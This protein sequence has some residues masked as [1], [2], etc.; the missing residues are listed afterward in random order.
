MRERL[1]EF[2]GDTYERPHQPWLCGLSEEG[3]PCPVGPGKR[4]QCPGASACHPRRE[5]DRWVCNRS[6]ARGGECETG[7]SPAGVCCQVYACTPL[8]SRRSRRGRFVWG[9]FL[10]TLGSVCLMMS[11]NWRNQILSPGAL[12]AQH[13]SLLKQG[14][15]TKQC[16]SCHAAANQPLRQ[17]LQPLNDAEPAQLSQTELCLECH[18][19]EI[20]PAAA[21]WAHN[22]DPQ[23]LLAKSDRSVTRRFDPTQEL[24]CSTCHQEHHGATHDLTWMSDSACQAC[25]EQQHQSFATDHPEFK[26]WPTRRR[27]RIAFDHGSHQMKH[28]P[29]EKQNFACATCHLPDRDGAFQQTLGYEATCAKC[30]ESK[31]EASWDTGVALFA[32]PMIDDETLRE[33]G[34]DVGQ[35][36]EQAVGDFDGALPPMTKLLLVADKRAAAA[37]TRL[38]ADFDFFDVDPEDPKQ[39]QAAAEIVVAT[40]RLLHEVSVQGQNALR[41]RI[42]KVLARQ[43]TGQEFSALTARL[44]AENLAVITGRWLSRL[45]AEMTGGELPIVQ[46]RDP[47]PLEID[48]DT[49]RE[50]VAAGGWFS[51]ETTLSIRYRPTGHADPWVTAWIDVLAE[52]ATGP[53][54]RVTQPLFKQMMDPAAAGQC[55][56]CHSLDREEEGRCEVQWLAKRPVDEPPSLTTFSHGPHL[57][58]AQLADC[59]AC[60]QIDPQAQVM[61]SYAQSSPLEFQSG[62]QPLTKQS[63]AECHTSHGAGDSCRQCHKY[64]VGEMTKIPW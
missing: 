54:A 50:R 56:S 9:C 32:L 7:P 20:N 46:Q 36:P 42:E 39:L 37:L 19:Q 26:N 45:P 43:L 49:A 24:A 64:H 60:H 29:K 1:Q 35:W 52:A 12:S 3:A 5:G 34:L 11:S 61:A 22:I 14:E 21:L 25:H 41:A 44:S 27:T 53:H 40:K 31:I 2:K 17:W 4:G 51:D 47:S 62:F 10:A 38:G 6:A 30:H 58:Q 33:R 13:A 28:F 63:C 8:R 23:Q 16:A 59:Q 48:R 55:G 57:S 15:S 18:K